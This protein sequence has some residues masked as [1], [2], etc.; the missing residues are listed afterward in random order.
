MFDLI[1]LAE[2]RLDVKYEGGYFLMTFHTKES[3]IKKVGKILGAVLVSIICVFVL[4]V[5]GIH[6]Y[7]DRMDEVSESYFALKVKLADE[8]A[9]NTGDRYFTK[10]PDDIT[11]VRDDDG[12]Y[13]AYFRK[14]SLLFSKDSDSEISYQIFDENDQHIIDMI[15]D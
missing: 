7:N 4:L 1:D 3:T 10:F 6:I 5:W 14:S 12:N 9:Q 8:Y 15:I 11:F 2:I 13:W